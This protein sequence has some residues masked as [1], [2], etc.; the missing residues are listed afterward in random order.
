[1]MR[2]EINP[3]TKL[4]EWNFSLNF[5][6]KNKPNNPPYVKDAIWRPIITIAESLS[7]KKRAILINAIAQNKLTN[8]DIRR[9]GFPPNQSIIVE[10]AKEFIDELKVDIAADKIPASNNPR[11]PT[12]KYSTMK[13]E[14]SLSFCNST[15]FKKSKSR[16]PTKGKIKHDPIS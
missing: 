16:A 12:G 13:V 2:L 10:D 14:N 1:M 9:V 15:P 3:I 4:E 5:V 8:L 11:R 7:S 6:S